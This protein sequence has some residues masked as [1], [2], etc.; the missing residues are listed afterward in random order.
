MNISYPYTFSSVLP[1]FIAPMNA[2]AVRE[3]PEGNVWTYEAKL[4]GY[5]CLASTR[6]GEVTLWSCRGQF[7]NA[8]FPEVVRA[9][10]KLPGETVIDG[11]IVLLDESGKIATKLPQRPCAAA[12]VEY[13]VYDILVLRGRSLLN[14]RLEARRSQLCDT[15]YKVSYPVIRSQSFTARPT[16]LIRAAK[17]LHVDGIIAKHKGSIYEPGTRSRA[18]LK[19]KLPSQ[20]AL[21]EPRWRPIG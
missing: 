16:D 12:S 3:L 14:T 7:L 10:E 15:L 21:T 1:R 11:E 13:Y 5:R 9:C 17:E 20:A 18:W 8:R 4:D 6:D 19:Y 2:T